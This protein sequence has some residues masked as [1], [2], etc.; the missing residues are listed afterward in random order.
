MVAKRRVALDPLEGMPWPLRGE[1]GSMVFRG[2]GDGLSD[3]LRKEI[4]DWFARWISLERSTAHHEKW[5]NRIVRDL[6]RELG[7][8]YEVVYYPYS[9]RR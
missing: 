6:E 3:R 2:P 4:T 7:D 9:L 1:D 8:T 5:A